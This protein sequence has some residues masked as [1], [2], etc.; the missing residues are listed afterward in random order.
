MFRKKNKLNYSKNIVEW[1]W[2]T[3]VIIHELHGKNSYKEL[4]EDLGSEE[5]PRVTFIIIEDFN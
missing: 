4:Q 1:P 2:A 3:P 5:M